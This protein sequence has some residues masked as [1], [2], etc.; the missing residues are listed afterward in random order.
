MDRKQ[1]R[2]SLQSGIVDYRDNSIHLNK[3][4]ILESNCTTVSCVSTDLVS[5]TLIMTLAVLARL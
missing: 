2:P 1:Q 5:H 4:L 3:L